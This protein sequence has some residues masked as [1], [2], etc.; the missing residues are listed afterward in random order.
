MASCGEVAGAYDDA[1]VEPRSAAVAGTVGVQPFLV[2]RAA[3]VGAAIGECVQA[4]ALSVQY[5][6]SPFA[7]A[8]VG[9]ASS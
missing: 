5:N 6:A 9:V 1:A 7:R 3:P 4:L 8:A 2:Q